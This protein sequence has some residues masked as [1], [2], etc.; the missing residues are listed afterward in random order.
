MTARLLT[1]TDHFEIKG[2]GLVLMPDFS[3][4]TDWRDRREIVRIVTP[5]GAQ[6]YAEAQLSWSHFVFADPSVPTDRRSRVVVSLRDATKAEV[7]IGSLVF[8]SEAT[9]AVLRGASRT[10]EPTP[11]VRPADERP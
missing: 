1:V 5:S 3:L 6:Q 11:P 4:P 10:A 9:S 8:A 7:P 2:R